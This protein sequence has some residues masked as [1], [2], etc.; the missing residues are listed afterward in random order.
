MIW[1]HVFEVHIYLYHT[2]LI[3]LMDNCLLLGVM[4]GVTFMIIGTSA[5]MS[6]HVSFGVTNVESLFKSQIYSGSINGYELL[7]NAILLFSKENDLLLVLLNS[8]TP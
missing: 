1:R 8:I 6:V 4:I 5:L 3:N 2:I 7:D